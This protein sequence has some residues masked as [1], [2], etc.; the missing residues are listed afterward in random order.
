LPKTPRQKWIETKE[1][2][3]RSRHVEVPAPIPAAPPRP[4]GRRVAFLIYRGNP[5]CGGQGVYTRHLTRELVALGHSVEVF[6]GPPWPEL[7]E[8]SLAILR[9]IPVWS[10]ALQVEVNAGATLES[11]AQSQTDPLIVQTLRLQ[12]YEEDRHG[13]M[14]GTLIER[15][16]LDGEAG[17]PAAYGG[18]QAFIDFG[19]NECL[20]SF[21]GFGI[22]RIARQVRFLP[23]ALI[24]LFSRVMY[25]EARHIVFFVNWITYER[26]VR[27]YGA[28]PLQVLPTAIGY[29]R[30]LK[31]TVGRAGA[32]NTTDK[33][34]AA[35]GDMKSLYL[36]YISHAKSFQTLH[37]AMP[38]AGSRVAN[39]MR[40]LLGKMISAS[41]PSRM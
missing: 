20:D 25:E 15:Y 40:P 26:C 11:F 38:K 9:S 3:E 1:S 39:I 19:Y 6:A 14:L 32:A 33:G 24:S 41:I 5:R 10:M 30:A 37:C 23:E 27:G 29:L 12:G 28:P 36:P 31:K 18:R 34:M 17:P 21:A 16:G 13:R 35:A 22:F 4:G 8:A 2:W 7:D